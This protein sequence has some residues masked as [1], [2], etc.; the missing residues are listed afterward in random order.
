MSSPVISMYPTAGCLHHHTEMVVIKPIMGVVF[1]Y[2]L[3][4]H[5][6]W[7]IAF[8][9]VGVVVAWLMVEEGEHRCCLCI[10]FH[11]MQSLSRRCSMTYMYISLPR[12]KESKERRGETNIYMLESYVCMCTVSTR[13]QRCSHLS[14]LNSSTVKFSWFL[15]VSYVPDHKKSYCKFLI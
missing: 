15:L 4:V 7:Y 11:M 3:G 9:H 12:N 2:C 13:Q 5:L 6:S 8:L 1:C 10:S 14:G